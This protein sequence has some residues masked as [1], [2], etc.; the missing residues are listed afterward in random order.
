M[1]TLTRRIAAL[2]ASLAVAGF[3]FGCESP[4]TEPEGATADQQE[5]DQRTEEDNGLFEGE[6]QEELGAEGEEDELA[7]EEDELAQQDQPIDQQDQPTEPGQVGQDQPTGQQ[8][9]PGEQL[10]YYTQWSENEQVGQVTH[11][12]A[13]TGFV[14]LSNAFEGVSQQVEQGATGGGPADEPAQPE[15]EGEMGQQGEMDDQDAMGQQGEMG[16][17]Q[18]QFDAQQVQQHTQQLEQIAQ[19]LEQNQNIYDHPQQFQQGVESTASI[20]NSFKEHPQF[21]ELSDQI[22]R[23]DEMAQ[24][25]DP[26]EPLAA[27]RQSVQSF[28]EQTSNVIGQMSQK[29]EEG[30]VGGGPADQQD[31]QPMQDEQ[32]QL[33]QEG[34]ELQ[35]EGE[36]L[37]QEGQELQQEGEQELEEQEQELEEQQEEWDQQQDQPTQDY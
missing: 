11:S 9:Q 10:D 14:I 12:Y 17:E 30:A 37:Q 24:N 15:Q 27:Q 33:E 1:S 13:S 26:D 19:Q 8:M 4:E 25:V 21:S 23:I 22:T 3:A 16:E 5:Q 32:D 7:P 2:L 34:D 31:Q 29:L 35:Q 28:F 6:A 18:A 20:L 36:E